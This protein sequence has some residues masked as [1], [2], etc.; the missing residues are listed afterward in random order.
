MDLAFRLLGDDAGWAPEKIDAAFASGKTTRVSLP[1][2][3]PVHLVYA[4]AFQGDGGSIEFRPD[5]YGRDRK[6]QAALFGK[7]SS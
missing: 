3:I 2:H 1:E 7:P 6:L 5:I 4:T